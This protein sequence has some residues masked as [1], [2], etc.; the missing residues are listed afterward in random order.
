MSPLDMLRNNH[1]TG[2]PRPWQSLNCFSTLDPPTLAISYQWLIQHVV[3]VSV[4]FHSHNAFKVHLCC[5]MDHT[6]WLNNPPLNVSNDF[7]VHSF[8]DNSDSIETQLA[9]EPLAAS[10]FHTHM[11]AIIP[12][13]LTKTVVSGL[14]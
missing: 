2:A 13:A 6:L 1:L 8:L 11:A 12:R 9:S 3:F 5:S 4:F 7:L 10:Q 14:L